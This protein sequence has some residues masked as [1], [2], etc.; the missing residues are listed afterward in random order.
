M[1]LPLP[2][3][4]AQGLGKS[5]LPLAAVPDGWDLSPGCEPDFLNLEKGKEEEEEERGKEDNDDDNNHEEFK[6]PETI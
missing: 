5:H 2:P 1:P 6:T 4:T 3:H